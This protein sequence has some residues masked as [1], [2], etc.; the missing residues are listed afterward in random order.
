MANKLYRRVSKRLT[1]IIFLSANHMTIL[2][3]TMC[4]ANPSLFPLL[5]VA[6]RALRA[7]LYFTRFV[8]LSFV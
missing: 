4:L 5:R 1:E 3:I 8:T 7:R 2:K 6:E